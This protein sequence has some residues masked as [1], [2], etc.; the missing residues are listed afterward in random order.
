MMLDNIVN[1]P[2]DLA[3]FPITPKDATLNWRDALQ[4][5]HEAS[6]IASITNDNGS[7]AIED[8]CER[9]GPFTR[10]LGNLVWVAQ[11]REKQVAMNL[12]DKRSAQGWSNVTCK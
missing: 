5:P 11:W 3:S 12:R 1:L 7:E 10:K 4:K 9:G 2:I 8:F 6:I